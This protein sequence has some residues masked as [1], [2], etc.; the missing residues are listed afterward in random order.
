MATVF[1]WDAAHYDRVAAPMTARGTQM[2]ER[3]P[4]RGDETVLDLGCGT[5]RVTGRLRERLPHGEVVAVDASAA[6]LAA[7][8]ARLA[9]GGRVR[10]VRADVGA[11]LPLPAA[12]AAL[13]TSALHWVPD[14]PALFRRL[15]AALRPGGHLALDFG[16]E[17]NIAEVVAAL[18]EVGETHPWNFPSPAATA[19]ALEAAGFEVREIEVSVRPHLLGGRAELE[20]YLRTVV[21]G[22]HLEGRD[23]AA[24]DRLVSAV[25]GRLRAPEIRYV[26][27]EV[28]ARRREAHAG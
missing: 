16:G 28:I 11:P 15:A 8:R 17:G 9:A 22:A 6:M 21:L 2:V 26:R 12:D 27:T 3:L 14:H 24:G 10:F 19:A 20:A 5:G 4:L 23:P 25:A 18:A 13:S 1:E 7:A